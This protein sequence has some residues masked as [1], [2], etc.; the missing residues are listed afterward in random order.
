MELISTVGKNIVIFICILSQCRETVLLQV[1][2]NVSIHDFLN[3]KEIIAKKF[4]CG[5]EN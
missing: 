2:K 4:K 3:R 5:E 1:C